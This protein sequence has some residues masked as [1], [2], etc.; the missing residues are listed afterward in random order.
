MLAKPRGLLPRPSLDPDAAVVEEAEA[1]P[2][3]PPERG[4]RFEGVAR[5]ITRGVRWG[6]SSAAIALPQQAQASRLERAWGTAR[7]E[8]D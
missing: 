3:P 1:E 6:S 2:E 8:M 7:G 4:G 5:W